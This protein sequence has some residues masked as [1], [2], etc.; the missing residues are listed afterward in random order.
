MKKILFL[1]NMIVQPIGRLLKKEYDVA[2]ADL[3][4]FV[5]TLQGKT[6]ADILVILFDSRFFYDLYPE[7]AADDRLVFLQSLLEAFRRNNAAGIVLGNLFDTFP[8]FNTGE[9]TRC[10]RELLDLNLGMEL[11]KEKI[12]DLEICDLFSVGVRLGAERLFQEKNRYLFQSP[13]T[14]EGVEAVAGEIDRTIRRIWAK[15]KKV[16]VL[17]GD[18]TLWGGIVGEDGI[19]GVACDENYPGIAYKRF[20]IYLKYLKDSGL[21]LTMVSKNNEADVRELF[22]KRLMPLTL[23]DF[24]VTK[25]NWRTKSENIAEIAYELNLGIDSLLFVDDNPFEIEEVR[26]ALPQVGTLLLDKENPLEN[27]TRLEAE[28]S[29]HAVAI[30]EEDRHKSEQYLGEKRRGEVFKSAADPEAFI[31]SLGITITWWRNNRAQLPRITQLINKTNQFNLTTRRY[32]QA[33]VEKIMERDT[34]FSFKVEDK[35]GDMGIVGVVIVRGGVIDTFLLS[36]RVLGRGIE[37]RIIDVVLDE[38]GEKLE[39]EYL[40]SSKNAQVE[41]LYERLGFEVIGREGNAKHYRFAWR[42]GSKPY[43][44]IKR[45]E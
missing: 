15:R 9:T 24:I 21:V 5:P 11:L 30:T 31:R 20:Q 42:A 12:A 26:N 23:D 18:N 17:D 13:F 29:V 28:P 10:Y 2:Y 27:I 36:C 35:F 33:E 4:A 43:I 45:G 44:E 40:P 14:K 19:E 16:L 25:I 39:A 34:I 37:E 32:T 7:S 1:S 8:R 3:D 38:C 6:D 41:D 22:E